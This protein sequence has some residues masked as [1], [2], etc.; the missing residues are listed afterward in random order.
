MKRK[1]FLFLLVGLA[2]SLAGLQPAQALPVPVVFELNYEY[3]GGT[4]PKG[5]AP[6]LRATF[7]D[8]SAG[9]VELKLETLDL[10]G[11]EFVSDWLFNFDD[12]YETQ[13]SSLKFDPLPGPL[14]SF[15]TTANFY[16]GGGAH[17]FDIMLG[18]PTA[19]ADRFGAGDPPYIFEIT[20]SATNFT[21]EAALF[22]VFN[23][24]KNPP[25]FKTVA[26]IQGIAPDGEESGWI[27]PAAVPESSTLLLVGVG[28]IGLAGFGRRRI[29]T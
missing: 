8:V 15:G 26:H 14:S 19:K 10:V 22:D 7:T 2:F 1:L 24:Y 11:D 12:R 18:F 23:N 9:K 27:A 3:S 6:W 21:L 5:T 16:G 29:K 17:G 13:V 25:Y 28:L 20:S 4:S